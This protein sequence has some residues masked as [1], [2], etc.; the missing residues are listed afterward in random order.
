MII[1]KELKSYINN[2]N[3]QFIKKNNYKILLIN[4]IQNNI[5]KFTNTKKFKLIIKNND[6]I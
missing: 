6:C 4:K 1:K 5:L 2:K 3:R